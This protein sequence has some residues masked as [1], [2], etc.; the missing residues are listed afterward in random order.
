MIGGVP[1]EPIIFVTSTQ[2]LCTTGPHPAGPV[3]IVVTTGDGQTSTFPN[4]FTYLP[5]PP[6]VVP[7]FTG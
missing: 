4:G 3:D 1:C 7:V 5:P 2:L 6:P